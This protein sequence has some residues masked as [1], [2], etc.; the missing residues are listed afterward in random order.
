MLIYNNDTVLLRA[1]MQNVILKRGNE[2]DPLVGI[3]EYGINGVGFII[4]KSVL[5]KIMQEQ[6]YEPRYPGMKV[7]VCNYT[8]TSDN[9]IV[10]AGERKFNEYRKE[11]EKN[12]D[13][14]F[15]T[16][17]GYVAG[18]STLRDNIERVAQRQQEREEKRRARRERRERFREEHES[19][20]ADVNIKR[21][22]DMFENT[23]RQLKDM[24][25]AFAKDDLEMFGKP[26]DEALSEVNELDHV[27][28]QIR[29][30]ESELRSKIAELSKVGPIG[31][32]KIQCQ[33]RKIHEEQRKLRKQY[34]ELKVKT[35]KYANR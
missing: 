25:E 35:S 9:R 7:D 33:I 10:P 30:K 4:K 27:T 16:N 34:D 23:A 12:P 26:L 15:D 24:K 19:E 22:L 18:N 3:Y 32:I 5:K 21:H 14:L 11:A 13:I 29:N 20:E 1:E 31:M 2:E 8:Y 28:E 17:S 6:S